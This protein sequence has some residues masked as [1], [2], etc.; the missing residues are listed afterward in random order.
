M[1]S[2][3]GVQHFHTVLRNVTV[4]YNDRGKR[5]SA[6]QGYYAS[7]NAFIQHSINVMR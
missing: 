6:L 7:L 4:L 3:A 2:N 1:N 5:K